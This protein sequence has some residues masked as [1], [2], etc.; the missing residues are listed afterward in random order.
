MHVTNAACTLK[1]IPTK[2]G[3]FL[4]EKGIRVRLSNEYNFID[5]QLALSPTMKFLPPAEKPEAKA[6]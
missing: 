4:I 1:N 3:M 6:L 5:Y 2:A